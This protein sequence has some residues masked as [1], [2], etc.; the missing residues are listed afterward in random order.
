MI[1]EIEESY[2]DRFED[3]EFRYAKVDAY[4]K[5]RQALR[6]RLAA[7]FLWTHGDT[8]EVIAGKLEIPLQEVRDLLKPDDEEEQ[9]NGYREQCA[10]VPNGDRLPP[11]F[12][13]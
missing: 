3:P 7:R 12:E 2:M 1:I 8:G 11:D 10:A 6:L 4:L 9:E 5:E 13:E